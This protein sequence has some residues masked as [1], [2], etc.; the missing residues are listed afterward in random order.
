MADEEVVGVSKVLQSWKIANARGDP[1]GE[2]VVRD[3]ELLY[4]LQTRDG[5]RQLALETVEADVEYGQVAE[6]ADL[7]RDAA[8]EVVV[9]ENNLVNR[10]SHAANGG[11][12][13]AAKV[14]IGEDEN[15]NRRGTDGGGDA[16]AE[17][18]GVE[19]DGV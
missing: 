9:D 15:G 11:G 8:S 4:A 5:V 1:T 16:V 3:V 14:V 17:A 7:R 19:E 18:V 12:D 6:Q 2:A 13:A 10:G